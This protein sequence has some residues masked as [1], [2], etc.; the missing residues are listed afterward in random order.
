MKINS[1]DLF[2]V[3]MRQSPVYY[4]DTETGHIIW[5]KL[6][7]SKDIAERCSY[8][9]DI[10]NKRYIKLPCI[11]DY[12]RK[13][14]LDQQNFPQE[15]LDEYGIDPTLPVEKFEFDLGRRANW[16]YDT[17]VLFEDY[18]IQVEYQRFA[19]ALAPILEKEWLDMQGITIV[20][21]DSH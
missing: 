2:L 7:T 17:H 14:F 20:T 16:S 15:V 13:S 12:L 8:D 5:P 19:R 10:T 4:L 21:E 1:R 18:D 11:V 3:G 9:I 6:D